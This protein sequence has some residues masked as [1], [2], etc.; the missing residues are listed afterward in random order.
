MA[1]ELQGR[2]IAILVANEGIEQVELTEPRAAL[3]RAGARVDLLAPEAGTVQAFDHLDRADAFPVDR[4]TAEASADDYDGLMLPGGVANPDALRMREDA[5]ALVAAFVNA[6]KPVAAICH[7]PWTL[8]QADA[9]RGRTLT[10]WPSLQ[11]DVRNAGGTW[12]DEAV[13]VDAG[14]VTSRGPDDL[15]AFSAAMVEAFAA[16]PADV[17]R[18]AQPARF[19]R[20]A[21]LS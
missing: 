19:E 21:I 17:R 18:R 13:V 16:G 9:V 8:V 11:T 4:T 10:S 6:G 2:R 15:P 12:V 1:D 14:L 3:E 7:A 20:S 5:V